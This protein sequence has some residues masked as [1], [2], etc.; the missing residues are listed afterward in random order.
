[1]A[2]SHSPHNWK[3]GREGRKEEESQISRAS[4]SHGACDR[5]NAL[6]L[7]KGTDAM[8]LL[9]AGLCLCQLCWFQNGL[10][11]ADRKKQQFFV[12]HLTGLPGPLLCAQWSTRCTLCSHPALNINLCSLEMQWRGKRSSSLPL[13]VVSRMKE[14]RSLISLQ[15]VYL[16]WVHS[17]AFCTQSC[18]DVIFLYEGCLTVQSCLDK[19][20][21]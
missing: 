4:C 12:S 1:M 16:D 18:Q 9:E 17:K 13:Y 21:T 15:L 11:L 8:P 2:L 3:L 10:A 19:S 7:C 14:S 5:H 20:L 6:G